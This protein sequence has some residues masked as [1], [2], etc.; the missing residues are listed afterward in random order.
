MP[1]PLLCCLGGHQGLK[2]MHPTKFLHTP[3]AC[4][5]PGENARSWEAL[6]EARPGQSSLWAGA[7]RYRR[8]LVGCMDFKPWWP[9][10][11]QRRGEGTLLPF[12]GS[13]NCF[14]QVTNAHCYSGEF[15]A[16]ILLCLSAAFDR[17]DASVFPGPLSSL[18]FSV[19]T[20][21]SSHIS[22]SFSVSY[23]GFLPSP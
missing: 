13:Q 12:H 8:N 20:L 4:S 22:F 21:S 17:I 5:F 16:F 3:A 10:R 19:A 2:S 7:L 6:G 9:P 14:Q 18:G 15:L 11:Q 23:V 1:S